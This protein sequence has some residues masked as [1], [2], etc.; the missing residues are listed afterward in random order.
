V[1]SQENHL[2][3]AFCNS[4]LTERK[5]IPYGQHSDAFMSGAPD[6]L[7]LVVKTLRTSLNCVVGGACPNL[8]GCAGC[9]IAIAHEA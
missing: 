4:L 2:A 5:R 1:S 7:D 8:K 6:C 3:N 9:K